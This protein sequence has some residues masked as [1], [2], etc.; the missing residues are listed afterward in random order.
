MI[1]MKASYIQR[2]NELLIA[3][4]KDAPWGAVIKVLDE[5]NT[6]GELRVLAPV[7]S[8]HPKW[9]G[10]IDEYRANIRR[11]PRPKLDVRFR[12][13]FPLLSKK[14]DSPAK[15]RVFLRGVNQ[16]HVWPDEM[17]SVFEEILVKHEIGGERIIRF[18]GDRESEEHTAIRIIYHT[19]YWAWTLTRMVFPGHTVTGQGRDEG[20]YIDWRSEEERELPK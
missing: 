14:L 15:I 3:L 9:D 4:R 8:K 18:F 7:L 11:W 2:R 16:R 5:V 10:T 19:E 1:F 13:N 17:A 20:V 12:I 6:L